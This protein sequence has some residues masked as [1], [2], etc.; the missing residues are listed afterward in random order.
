MTFQL[1]HEDDEGVSRTMEC[2][3]A[4]PMTGGARLLAICLAN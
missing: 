2:H 3:L 1:Y 4:D